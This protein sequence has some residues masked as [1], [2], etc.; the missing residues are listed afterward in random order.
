MSEIRINLKLHQMWYDEWN[1]IVRWQEKLPQEK[2]ERNRFEE[3]KLNSYLW[4]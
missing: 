2:E 3:L 1:S 4:T